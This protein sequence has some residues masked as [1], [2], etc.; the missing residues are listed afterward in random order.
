M[1]LWISEEKLNQ[2]ASFALQHIVCYNTNNTNTNN[3]NTV[4][5]YQKD[6]AV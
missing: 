5:N 2:R 4:F 6:G 3:N 1:L